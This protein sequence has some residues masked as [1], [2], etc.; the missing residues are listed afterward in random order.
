[1]INKKIKFSVPEYDFIETPSPAKQHIP[2]WYRDSE[3]FIGGKFKISQNGASNHGLKLCV[4]F[5]DAMT[6]GYMAT[7]WT[8]VVV[9]Q[10]ELGPT[11]RWRMGPDP[12]EQR[13]RINKTL[14]T[15]AGHDDTSYA[16]KSLFNIQT[17]KGYSVLI[18]HPLNRSDLPFTTLS[19]IA[20]SDK[21][22]ARGKLPFFLKSGFEG[23]IPVGTPMYQIIPIKREGWVGED[24]KSIE[25]EGLK[26]EIKTSRH[27]YGWYKKFK[28]DRKS[29]E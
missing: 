5:L 21:T 6:S 29:Y 23:I 24:D 3:R 2:D 25:H 10:T 4:P 20:D 19:G 7:L 13:P 12:I 9:E 17:P 22:L 28:W 1:M 16:W 15:P 8:D 18:T 26:N 11:L 27:A 14:P